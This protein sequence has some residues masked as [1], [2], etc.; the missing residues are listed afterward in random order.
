MILADGL[1]EIWIGDRIAGSQEQGDPPR[2]LNALTFRKR[3]KIFFKRSH[4]GNP[5]VAMPHNGF[6]RPTI[7]QGERERRYHREI[8]RF[9]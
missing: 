2:K 9:E 7:E 4:D 5:I 3:P 8:F 6:A 1:I